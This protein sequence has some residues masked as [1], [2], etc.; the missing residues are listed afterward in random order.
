M[1][2]KLTGRG[3][4]LDFK[5]TYICEELSKLLGHLKKKKI[6]EEKYWC[7]VGMPNKVLKVLLKSIEQNVISL[8]QPQVYVKILI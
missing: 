6:A 1:G 4:Q 2:E 5:R 8:E 7:Q 3:K